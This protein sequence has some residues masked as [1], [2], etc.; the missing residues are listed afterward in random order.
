MNCIAYHESSAYNH[1]THTF[2]QGETLVNFFL[3][4]V[5]NFPSGE[6]SEP[7][8]FPYDDYRSLQILNLTLVVSTI[9]LLFKVVFP[10]LA[11]AP[12]V[13]KNS[14]IIPLQIG[15]YRFLSLL[16]PF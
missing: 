4:D 5:L 13:F 15:Y 2:S 7:I 16:K 14:R 11:I 8:E 3:E 10:Q 9:F 6:D 12:R 1:K